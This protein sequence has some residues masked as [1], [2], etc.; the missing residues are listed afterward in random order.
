PHVRDKERF[1]RL[2]YEVGLREFR[3]HLTYRMAT[4]AGLFTNTVFALIFSAVYTALYRDTGGQREVAGFT[5]ADALAYVWI[6]QALIMVV[7][8]WGTWDI[9]LGV[10]GG[11]IYADLFKPFNYFGY[12][13]SRDLGRASYFTV[14]RFIPTI[15]VGA[16]LFDLAL[17]A[18]VLHWAGFLLTMAMGVVVS[19][20]IRF[21]VNL[22]TFWLTDVQGVRMLQLSVWSFLSGFLVPLNFLPTGLRQIAEALPFRTM[23]MVPV[24][25]LLGH[26][27][28]VSALGLQTLW[29]IV[30][31][32]S[33]LALLRLAMRKVVI[34]GG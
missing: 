1:V 15:M 27:A 10:R 12:W 31:S 14:S 18:S 11:D 6:T 20:A 2:Y 3:R 25:V 7:A 33:G 19:F 23:M 9:A 16:W 22:S 30:L 17:P 5:E 8:L 28:V 13:L 26:Q 24:N 32:A 29:A 21:I 34:Q 4:I